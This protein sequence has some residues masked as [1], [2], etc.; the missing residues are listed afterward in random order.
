MKKFF[1]LLHII[2]L[3]V[4]ADL[5]VTLMYKQIGGES[6]GMGGTVAGPDSRGQTLGTGKS[7][8]RRAIKNYDRI[9]TRNMFNVLVREADPSGAATTEPADA[10]LKKTELKLALWGTVTAG[11]TGASYAVIEDK[12]K[13]AQD[14]YQIGDTVQTAVIKQILRNR[15]ILTLDGEDQVLE[16]DPTQRPAKMAGSLKS[17]QTGDKRRP[18]PG[19]RAQQ[20]DKRPL[21]KQVRVRP[22]YKNGEPS[23]LVLYG[24]R[25]RSAFRK[26]GLKNGDIVQ[27]INGTETL[28][29]ADAET[30]YEAIDSGSD[31]QFDIIRRGKKKEILYNAEDESYGEEAREEDGPGEEESD[32]PGE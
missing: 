11:T 14:L 3:T 16:V 1:V 23:G 13:K 32:G 26:I 21:K 7:E 28:M 19:D 8:D 6:P 29:E 10:P 24:M 12:K 22:Y 2:L 20:E 9:N 18:E 31:L 17:A 27:G 15:I 25:P 30:L 4:A 5:G